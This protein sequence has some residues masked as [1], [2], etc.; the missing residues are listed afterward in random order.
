MK[1]MCCFFLLATKAQ[2]DPPEAEVEEGK[3]KKTV[4]KTQVNQ[5]MIRSII[6]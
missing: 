3:R 4:N 6:T 2:R 5:V 1:S